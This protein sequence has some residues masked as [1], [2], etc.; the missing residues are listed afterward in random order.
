[1]NTIDITDKSPTTAAGQ[2]A[3]ATPANIE[4]CHK[5]AAVIRP[6]S[7]PLM[8]NKITPNPREISVSGKATATGQPVGSGM[9]L[10]GAVIGA[11]EK[12]REA[13]IDRACLVQ[14]LSCAEADAL[15]ALEAAGEAE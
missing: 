4:R 1:M 2:R 15:D 9:D 3:F 14:A 11:K 6:V 13:E 7:S 10:A 5:A 8:T 12:A